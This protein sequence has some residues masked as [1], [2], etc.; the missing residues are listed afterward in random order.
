MVA[1]TWMETSAPLFITPADFSWMDLSQD[2][3]YR[4]EAA[5]ASEKAVATPHN[6]IGRTRQRRSH[7]A[8]C[9]TSSNHIQVSKVDLIYEN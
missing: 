8:I 9:V 2:Y 3:Q 1:T 4:R 5:V 6:I 7:Y